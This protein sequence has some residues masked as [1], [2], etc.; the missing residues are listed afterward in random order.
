MAEPISI[1]GFLIFFLLYLL[2]LRTNN[3]VDILKP[4]FLVFLVGGII[5]LSTFIQ[6]LTQGGVGVYIPSGIA[7]MLSHI[8]NS[9]LSAASSE[10]GSRGIKNM[11]YALGLYSIWMFALP[12]GIAILI[13][14]I[15]SKKASPN[16]APILY[17]IFNF[18]ITFVIFFGMLLGFIP[19]NELFMTLRRFI[20]L[21]L[22]GLFPVS[23]YIFLKVWEIVK[24]QTKFGK[25][26]KKIIS[27]IFIFILILPALPYVSFYV[28]ELTMHNKQFTISPEEFQS[29]EW[30]RKNTQGDSVFL[31]SL[32]NTY[33]PTF[34]MRS[35]YI[36]GPYIISDVNYEVKKIEKRSRFV[37]DV[38]S[39][40]HSPDELV[41]E[42]SKRQ[43]RYIYIGP[44][45]KSQYNFNFSEYVE[46][47][48]FKIAYQ[49]DDVVIMQVKQ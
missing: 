39:N 31:V 49:N 7:E 48:L 27:I 2:I 11:R 23:A 28:F 17:F 37:E 34:G 6:T 18:S 19:L 25:L 26:S 29:M 20:Q 45:E 46:R 44:L 3:I 21:G 4:F 5:G 41:S 13:K 16:S 14:D 43:I 30:I 36:T 9:L 22:V 12:L 33:L 40:K 1:V 38:Y 15:N 32:K 8:K 42:L 10:T 24:N 47:G 35:V